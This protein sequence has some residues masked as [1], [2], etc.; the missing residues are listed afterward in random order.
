M[1]ENVTLA[2]VFVAG[3]LSFVSPCVLPLVPGYI[4]FISGVSLEEMKKTKKPVHLF[5]RICSYSI[6]FIIGFTVVFVSL[7]ATA[8]AFG[9]LM[10]SNLLILKRVAGVMIIIFG[11]HVAG[12]FRIKFLDYERR[13]HLQN[14]RVGFLNAFVLGLAFSFGWVPCIGPILAAILTYAATQETVREGILLLTVYSLGLGIPF[15]LT[16]MGIERS[17]EF[18]KK[19]KKHYRIIELVSGALLLIMGILILT[20]NLERLTYYFVF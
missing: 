14:K 8:T 15:L 11:L 2:A 12:L 17:L 3:I 1:E 9:D 4:S 6:L 16:A 10:F 20:D 5:L 7:G 18:F 13:F 19:I